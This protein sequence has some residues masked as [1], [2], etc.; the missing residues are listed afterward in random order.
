MVPSALSPLFP[1]SPTSSNLS[2]LK[3]SL[4]I[5]PASSTSSS[6]SSDSSVPTPPSPVDS[7]DSET[8]ARRR[9]EKFGVTGLDVE[10][11]RRDDEDADAQL[12]AVKAHLRR[13]RRHRSLFLSPHFPKPSVV[14]PAST[15]VPP[16]HAPS[17]LPAPPPEA[18]RT[19]E[20]S[21]SSPLSPTATKPVTRRP[22]RSSTL[23]AAQDIPWSPPS[24][25]QTCE[26]EHSKVS[27]K[28]RRAL[29][30]L[31][32]GDGHHHRQH[33]LTDPKQRQGSIDGLSRRESKRR[34]K[35]EVGSTGEGVLFREVFVD[36]PREQYF[37]RRE[38]ILRNLR[39][40]S[41]SGAG[42][43]RHGPGSTTQRTAPGTIGEEPELEGRLD[44]FDSRLT[45]K[46]TTSLTGA[47]IHD[48]QRRNTPVR[49][50]S[51]RWKGAANP[52]SEGGPTGFPAS[53]MGSPR[54]SMTASP[55]PSFMSSV[56]PPDEEPR[57]SG[58]LGSVNMTPSAS[59][60]GGGHGLPT[61]GFAMTSLSPPQ[62]NSHRHRQ[63][64]S[65]PSRPGSPSSIESNGRMS[66]N[67]HTLLL[68][69]IHL[70][71]PT[72]TKEATSIP[73]ASPKLG[74]KD[75]GARP[76]SPEDFLRPM[77]YSHGGS[78]PNG[79]GGRWTHSPSMSLESLFTPPGQPS[80]LPLPHHVQPQY[81]ESSSAA[82]R[83]A[84][85]S[86]D[87]TYAQT[88]LLGPTSWGAGATGGEGS[89]MGGSVLGSEMGGSALD[90]LSQSSV[91]GRNRS[92][93]RLTRMD[94][95]RPESPV[96]RADTMDLGQECG[97]V[98]WERLWENQRGCASLV[99][100][101][102][103]TRLAHFLWLCSHRILFFGTPR[104]SGRMLLPNEP[105][106]YTR[107]GLTKDGCKT[108]YNL[109]NY[110]ASPLH[111]LAALRDPTSDA[112]SS[113][114]N[115]C[116][117]ALGS[118]RANGWS[119]CVGTERR[120][121]RAVSCLYS[122]L[123]V[124]NSTDSIPD[125]CRGIQL[126]VQEEGL[127]FRPPLARLPRLGPKT[128]VVRKDPWTSPLIG[129]DPCLRVPYSLQDPSSSPSA[130][131]G[132]D[133]GS[134]LG[135]CP[136]TLPYPTL[137]P[138]LKVQQRVFFRALGRLAR[139]HAGCDTPA[140]AL[141]AAA[142]GRSRQGAQWVQMGCGAAADVEEVAGGG[143]R[144]DPGTSVVG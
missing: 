98:V 5:D 49:S 65:A 99:L 143:R 77:P 108:P 43:S 10:L 90:L 7:E 132:C 67:G 62:A 125:H 57:G 138:P 131:N 135:A 84:L 21:A 92:A 96:R 31:A 73:N 123:S 115:S 127:A 102:S 3:P 80:S 66:P 88:N 55:R 59:R 79:H 36:S 54:P 64:T 82:R 110:Q 12:A 58:G 122:A 136:L 42:S 113:C 27:V 112:I 41:T 100:R 20:P 46:S 69:P 35:A 48:I 1:A 63:S 104:F 129:S 15:F 72:P 137:E 17:A 68:P 86:L 78:A 120:T 51:M 97:E 6:S 28:V 111:L 53:A 33:T 26:K 107:P 22:R 8:H 47:S 139:L 32:H 23:T 93:T 40:I 18:Q 56:Y 144:R 52:F 89:R 105:G 60:N 19:T 39:A 71:A 121:R 106:M 81:A 74:D 95:A 9:A 119:T 91:D 94:S 61:E 2:P 124:D 126:V 29:S 75:W 34:E 13:K 133:D 116:L 134:S 14:S 118:G 87:T 101:S 50:S 45:D 76:S 83:R 103:P 109:R 130:N 30:L 70:S 117:T 11:P 141:R 37:G 140:V 114:F 44:R 25:L 85:A 4:P 128:R 24:P 16:E 38:S 142:A